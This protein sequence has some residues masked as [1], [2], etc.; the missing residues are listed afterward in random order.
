MVRQALVL[1]ANALVAHYLDEPAA[2]RVRDVLR[3]ASRGE[4]TLLMT[5]VNAAEVLVAVERHGGFEAN[6]RTLE[7]LQ[8]LPVELVNIDLELAARAA[9]FKAGGGIA[10]GDAFAIALAHREGV[11]VLTAD[12]EFERVTDRVDVMWLS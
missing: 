6:Q 8:L 12:R 4:L 11:P 1:D 5:A 2:D 3:Q 9:W 7:N 10:Y